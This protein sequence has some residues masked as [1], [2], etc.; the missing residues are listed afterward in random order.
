MYRSV[1][2]ALMLRASVLHP[3][4]LGQWPDLASSDAAASWRQWLE[5]ALTIPGFAAALGHASPDLA[6]R[7]TA[8]VSGELAQADVRRVV[9]AVMRYLLRATSR[10]TPFGL[11]AGVAPATANR[12]GGIRWGT[13]HRP[14]ARIPAA[15]LARVLDGL[16]SDP[17]VRP[18]LTVR[19][20]NLLVQRSGQ[21]VLEYRAATSDPR[22]APAHL[23]IKATDSVRAVLALAAEPIRWADLRDK[24]AAEHGA[25]HNDA[26]RLISQ[27]VS[28]RLLLTSLR[29]PSTAPDPL[30][31]LVDELDNATSASGNAS[32]LLNQLRT[33]RHLQARHDNAPNMATADARRRDLGDAAAMISPSPAIGVDLRLDCDLVLPTT[34]T[35]E[36]GRAAA[37][38]ARLA[39]P[40]LPRWRDWHE[41]FLNRYGLHALVP[42]LDAVDAQV[43]LG[44]PAG[45]TGEPAEEAALVTD[46]D[47]RLLVL[48]LRAALR[49]EHEVVLDDALL[50][51]VAGAA[52]NEIFPTA[53]LTVR[54]HADSVCAI[55]DGDFQLSIVRASTQAFSTAG[56]FLDLFGEGQRRRIASRAADIPPASEGALLAQLAAVTRYT[57]SLDVNRAA[58]VLPHLIPVGEYHPASQDVIGLDDIAVTADAHRLYLVSI[59]RQRALQPVAVNAVEPVRHAHPL[60]RFLAEAPVALATACSPMEWGPAAKG[61]PFLP[62]LR[63]GRTLLSPARWQLTAAELPDRQATWQQWDQTLAAWRQTTGCPAAVWL[64]VGDQTLGLDLHEPAHRA[65]LRDHLTREPTAL[66]RVIPEGNGWIGGHP[67]EI[68]IPLTATGPRPAAPRLS[69][70]PVDVRTHGDLPG[71]SHHY[72]KIYARPSE[73]TTILSSHLPRLLA[74]R[75]D[76]SSWF[77]R[78][79]DPEPHLRLRLNGLPI[80]A[81]T[82]WVRQLRDADLTRRAQWDTDFPEPGRF[83]GPA[84]YQATT[85]VFAADSEATLAELAVTLRCPDANRQAL[86]AASMV[87]LV[88]AVIG[89]LNEALRW[90]ISRT[91]THRP[92]P[93]RPLY[94]QAILLANPFDHTALTSLPGG[95]ALI[96]RWADRRR[97]VAAWR[98]HLSATSATPPVDLLPDLLHL[99]HVRV[100]GLDLDSERACLHLAR[101]AALSWKTRSTP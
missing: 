3:G 35:A 81:I 39:R 63:Y 50:E 69:S 31:H 16:E 24:L 78:H 84:A 55:E 47:R 93:A 101:A 22:G 2:D 60:T 61:L 25:P 37:V 70:P 21:V 36:A 11:F 57:V 44:Y 54:V 59:S 33:L 42:V 38:L 18:H 86:T 85:A 15:W 66:L 19:A 65:V 80:E 17:Q 62:A 5:Q 79:A 88:A 9:L 45:S 8:A 77:L 64:G 13:A 58:P 23:R 72:L 4:L 76:G 52:P 68:V 96:Q 97:A 10:A 95:K 89:N 67:H 43:G 6:G 90:L 41:R 87:D 94:D 29:P 75:P 26:E 34:V 51:Q 14:F 27:M 30:P 40:T 56:R 99:H 20:N 71:G 92:A 28:Q 48:A 98:D 32:G 49:R 82:S 83:G 46:R 1:N 12:T 7:T 74:Q 91:R 73:Q 100:I 53:E